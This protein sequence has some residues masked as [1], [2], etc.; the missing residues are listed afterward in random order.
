MSQELIEKANIFLQQNNFP[1]AGKIFRQL[2]EED[3]NA[4]CASRYLHCLRKAG[5]PSQG[6]TQG[7]KVSS[8]F[9]NNIAIIIFMRY[10]EETQTHCYQKIGVPH[11]SDK[12]Y[13]FIC[14]IEFHTTM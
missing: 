1:E 14:E 9:P 11:Y 10:K 12:R 4:Y 2:W 3:N 6:L 8:Q 13:I 7:E 5:Y